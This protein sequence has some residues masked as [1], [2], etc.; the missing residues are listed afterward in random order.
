LSHEHAPDGGARARVIVVGM[1]AMLV[2]LLVTDV[3]TGSRQ[4]HQLEVERQALDQAARNNLLAASLGRTAREHST[5]WQVRK[6]GYQI[7]VDARR[8]NRQ[9]RGI[10]GRLNVLLPKDL[11]PDQSS[12]VE[13]LRKLH[14]K[15]LDRRFLDELVRTQRDQLEIL[16]RLQALTTDPKLRKWAEQAAKSTAADQRDAA[17]RRQ[18]M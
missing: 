10:A 9:L 12:R 1:G 17:I 13:A 11:T 15:E 8:R 5:D 7:A 14:G 2:L 3:N 6:L 4:T 16:Q 18:Q